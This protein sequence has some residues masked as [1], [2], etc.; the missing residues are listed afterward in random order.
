MLLLSGTAACRSTP[1]QPQQVTLKPLNPPL[2]QDPNIQIYFNHT[3]T[4]SYTEPYRQQTRFGDDLEQIIVD[5]I[6]EARSTVDVAVQELR[7]P[8]IATALIERHQAG[9]RA[10]LILEQSYS[11]PWSQFSP[12]EVIQLPERDQRRY[13]QF[14][15]LAD[16]NQDG[17]LSAAEINQRDALQ[18]IFDAGIP[19]IDDTGDGSKGSGLMHHKFVVV[20]GETTISTSANF[21]TS[22]IHG[23]FSE[24]NSRGNANNLVKLRSNQLAARFTQEFEIM[25]GDGPGGLNNSKFG[26]QKPDRGGELLKIGEIPVALQFAPTKPSQPWSGSANALINQVLDSTEQTV[27][28]A[29]FVFSAQRLVNTLEEKVQQGRQVKGLIDPSFAY[30]Y[31]SE[32]L[33]MRGIAIPRACTYE[34]GNRPWK[35]PVETVGTPKLSPGDNLHHKFGVVDDE[36]VISGSHNWSEA[37]NIMNDET[38]L[39][40]ESP[41]V[42]AHFNQEFER[43]YRGANLTVPDRVT[44]KMTAERQ[45]CGGK[46]AAPPAPLDIDP[47][48]KINLNQ[49]SLAELETLPGIGPR[50][51]QAI[52]QTRRQQPFVSLEDFQ[53]VPGIGPQTVEELRDRVTW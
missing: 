37:A 5:T 24:P 17:Q 30:R 12:S 36:I 32:A 43:L 19:W 33:D 44:E 14:M 46:I 51:A 38:L 27:H 31:Y 9:V 22:G 18:M 53:R 20:D 50:T 48:Q 41:T 47:T 6:A 3:E 35:T 2:P 52:I 15:A 26:T 40:I 23:D 8:K 28:F 45:Q 7:L 34:V 11:I 42:A 21:T 4:A 13:A 39:V 49:A 16:L 10:R 29:L 25:W 1:R